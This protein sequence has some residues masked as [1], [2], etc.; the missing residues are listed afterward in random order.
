MT[1]Y[2]HWSIMFSSEFPALFIPSERAEKFPAIS[3]LFFIDTLSGF[4]APSVPRLLKKGMVGV[5]SPWRHQPSLHR[6]S[7]PGRILFTRHR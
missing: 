7:E 3:L 6:K 4:L 2:S 1:I 5:S